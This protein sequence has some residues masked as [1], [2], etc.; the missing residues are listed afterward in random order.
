MTYVESAQGCVL[1]VISN[2]LYKG[3]IVFAFALQHSLDD[4]LCTSALWDVVVI[5]I[6]RHLPE[7]RCQP[8]NRH[9]VSGTMLRKMVCQN[10]CRTIPGLA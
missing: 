1:S 7:M 4:D 2:T 9:H 3:V 6:Y 10:M 8:K 5:V